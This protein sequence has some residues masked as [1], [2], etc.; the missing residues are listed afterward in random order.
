MTRTAEPP[1]DLSDD[2]CYRCGYQLRGVADD[3]PCPEC[4]LL[5]ERSRRPSDELHDTRPGWLARLAWGVRLILLA[6]LAAGAW[7][8]AA[9]AISE[10][11]RFAITPSSWAY[12]FYYHAVWL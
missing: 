9:A 7:P 6:L 8:F 12:V 3:Q 11:G 1:L 5:A 4:G 10:Y 2:E